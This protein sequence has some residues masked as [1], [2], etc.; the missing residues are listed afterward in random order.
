MKVKKAAIHSQRRLL[1][2]K[3][4]A[5]L[6]LRPDRM[7]PSG[8]L[9]AVRGALGITARQ[10]GERLGVKHS[11]I[12]QFEQ[13]EVTGKIS[14][15]ALQKVARG[16]R[17]RVIYAVVP[18]ELFGSLE[19]IVDAQAVQAA[20]ELVARVEH[21]MR[22]ENQGIAAEHVSKH[23]QEM[24]AQLKAKMDKSIWSGSFPLAKHL[25]RK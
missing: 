15:E 6:P 24:A 22:L 4:H 2:R 3:L 9:K 5:W 11:A 23:T 20:Y 21:T 16:M 17:C 14:L 1:D 12:L 18:E 25:R 10:L 19:A 7:P 8:W 13:R